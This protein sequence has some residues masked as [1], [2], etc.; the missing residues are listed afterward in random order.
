[1]R[2]A[3]VCRAVRLG[4]AL[5]VSLL[6]GAANALG[7][8]R[9]RDMFPQLSPV[10]LGDALNVLSIAYTISVGIGTLALAI[11]TMGAWAVFSC[12]KH[13]REDRAR[14][15]TNPFVRAA[16]ICVLGYWVTNVALWSLD[17]A[18]VKDAERVAGI[19][20]ERDLHHAVSGSDAVEDARIGG[21]SLIDLAIMYQMRSLQ[22]RPPTLSRS[23]ARSSRSTTS[24][25]ASARDAQAS[26]TIT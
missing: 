23:G 9:I 25:S 16:S 2:K 15:L 14:L 17:Y 24:R 8:M 11:D 5:R 22:R 1:M 13:R 4:S 21:D 3:V 12:F 10:D 26:T 19:A 18:I 20:K 6:W 7:S